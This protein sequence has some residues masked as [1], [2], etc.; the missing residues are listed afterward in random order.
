MAA[1]GLDD[2]GGFGGCFDGVCGLV[3]G[4]LSIICCSFYEI[5]PQYLPVLQQ[6]TLDYRF[7]NQA[8]FVAPPRIFADLAV[9]LLCFYIPK[10]R[11]S[12]AK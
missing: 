12:R 11:R 8:F 6:K 2:G 5:P 7:D 1:I 9:S 10:N 3:D 4:H